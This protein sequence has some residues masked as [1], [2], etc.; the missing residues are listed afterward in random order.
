ME[1]Q[2]RLWS[3]KLTIADEGGRG[4]KPN[5][6][7]CWRGGGGFQEPLILADVI[8]EQPPR[9]L[10]IMQMWAISNT[11]YRW[12]RAIKILFQILEPENS[13]PEYFIGVDFEKTSF[14]AKLFFIVVFFA[15]SNFE[16]EITFI[17][18]CHLN[19]FNWT[20]FCSRV[21]IKTT[22]KDLGNIFLAASTFA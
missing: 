21:G 13:A 22:K 15:L 6:D 12:W 1:V 8:C 16:R 14:S 11:Q 17:H 9:P 4:G 7:H 20:G 3:Q 10:P 2:T 18:Y 19:F 5:A